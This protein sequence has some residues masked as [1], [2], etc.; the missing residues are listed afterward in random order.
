MCKGR[1]WCIEECVQ[2]VLAQEYPNVEYLVQDGASRDGTLE[3]LMKYR[4]RV[5]AK[6]SYSEPQIIG[7]LR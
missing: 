5:L 7:F 2:S 1:A 4:D 3:V 6:D